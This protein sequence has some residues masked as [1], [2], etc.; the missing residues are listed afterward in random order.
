MN[1]KAA[2]RLQT[3]RKSMKTT[4][5]RVQVGADAIKRVSRF[6]DATLGETLDELLQNARRS[7]ATE[8]T[9]TLNGSELTLRDNGAGIAIATDLL[10]FGKS[11]WPDSIRA[12]EDPA[13]MGLYSLA[14]THCTIRSRRASDAGWRVELTPEHFTGEKSANVVEDDTLA[15]AGTEITLRL[16]ENVKTPSQTVRDHL[17]HSALYCPVK[18]TLDGK[19]LDQNDFLANTKRVVRWH[20]IRIGVTDNSRRHELNFHGITIPVPD[21]PQVAAI[22]GKW[23]AQLDL[24]TH[25]S[26]S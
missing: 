18:V 25:P 15:S 5:I 24:S 12:S 22:K 14:R 11:Q 3:N 4:T 26:W 23:T 1:H 13:G 20:G 2:Q 19:A 17:Q 7:G 16:P 9:A 8:V 6:F 10:T 21:M